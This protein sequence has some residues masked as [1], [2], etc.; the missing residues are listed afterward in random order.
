MPVKNVGTQPENENYSLRARVFREI[1]KA[2]LSGRLNPGDNLIES[3]LCSELG[4]SRTPIREAIRQLELEGLVR[5]VPNKGTVVVGISLKDIED[6]YA[7]RMMVEGLASKWAAQ[8]ITSEEAEKLKKI[9][10][11][12]DFY[13]EQ[14]DAEQLLEID[15]QFHEL[16]YEASKSRPLK[17]I[18]ASFHHYISHAR[19]MSFKTTGRARKA[20][21]E[22]K[23]ILDAIVSRDGELAE[24]LTSLH[25]KNAATNLIETL[26]SGE[27]LNS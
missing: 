15:S 25:I 3:H 1:E 13:V 18:L 17:H 12:Q 9:I 2:I 19:E 10:A 14:E 5:S 6:I 4:V 24:K 27:N 8:N 7:I 20:A 16:I 22:H 11:L 23:E 21:D 26:R